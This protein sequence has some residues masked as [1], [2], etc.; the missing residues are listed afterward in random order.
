MLSCSFGTSIYLAAAFYG[1]FYG[2][3][4]SLFP[5]LI[6]DL[7]GSAHSGAIGGFI[8][9]GGGILGGWGPALAGYLRDVNGNYHAAFYLCL[10]SAICSVILFALLPKP[11][12]AI[13][14]TA[15]L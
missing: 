11:K 5:A 8:A 4:A 6:G 12:R 1:C 10:G 13:T 9:A 7:F 3:F 14:K 2:G 15:T